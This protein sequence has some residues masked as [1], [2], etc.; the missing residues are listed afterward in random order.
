MQN[1]QLPYVEVVLKSQF[2]F[3]H[4]AKIYV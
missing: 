3:K 4:S 2:G 1:N